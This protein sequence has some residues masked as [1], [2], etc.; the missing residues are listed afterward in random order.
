MKRILLLIL[1]LQTFVSFC[2][3]GWTD[4]KT[5]D[6]NYIEYSP[7]FFSIM[8]PE[9]Y[10]AKKSEN[11]DNKEVCYCEIISP[12]KAENRIRIASGNKS[13]LEKQDIKDIY[14]IT[15]GDLTKKNDI[16]KYHLLKDN[17]FILKTEVNDNGKNLVSYTKVVMGKN[18]MS[19]LSIYYHKSIEAQ[20]E[21]DIPK[22]LESFSSE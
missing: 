21:N 8:I 13:Y 17:W 12:Y 18:Y 9:G 5:S 1:L 11:D 19:T 7:C 4:G 20:M 15:I 2:Q 16:L 3:D 6:K 10:Q 22:M 14:T